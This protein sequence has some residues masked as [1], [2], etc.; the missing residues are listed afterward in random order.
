MTK[1]LC[2]SIPSRGTRPP[3]AAF[4]RL[5]SPRRRTRRWPRWLGSTRAALLAELV[6]GGTTSELARRLSISPASASQHTS[7]LRRAGLATSVRFR[8]TVHHSL[9]VQGRTLLKG[10]TSASD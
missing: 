10:T 2:S 5:R 1:R 9:T 8:N 7:V 6:Q 4:G 3:S